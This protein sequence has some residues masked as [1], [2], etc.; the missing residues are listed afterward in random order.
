MPSMKKI[1][2]AST[3]PYRRELLERLAVPFESARPLIDEEKEKD[4]RLSP[5]ALAEH[6]ALLKARSLAAPGLV[7]IGGDQLVAFEGRILGK[8]G[9]RDRAIGQL[10]AMS[11]KTHELMTAICVI[12]GERV[13][14]HTDVTRLTLKSLSRAQIEK[15]VDRDEPF[16]CAGSYKIE[17]HGIALIERL[18]SDDFTAIQGLPLLALSR[19]LTACGIENP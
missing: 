13:L 2:L 14:S 11:G 18:E 10:T 5:R 7:V 9:S 19:M 1:L 8:P 16:D 17:K 6:L 15:I 4:P 3:S 12:D